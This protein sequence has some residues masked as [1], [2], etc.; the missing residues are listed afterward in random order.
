VE[1]FQ[2]AFLVGKVDKDIDIYNAQNT[3]CC[4]TAKPGQ[5]PPCCSGSL[6]TALDWLAPYCEGKK[7]FPIKTSPL[8]VW[9]PECK[10]LY[11]MAAIAF[12][13]ASYEAIYQAL[14]PDKGDGEICFGI[15]CGSWMDL[16][17]PW[18]PVMFKTDDGDTSL[19]KV[20]PAEPVSWN[21]TSSATVDPRFVSFTIDSWWLEMW[22]LPGKWHNSTLWHNLTYDFTSPRLAALVRALGPSVLRVGGGKSDSGYF[23]GGPHPGPRP[24]SH[25]YCWNLTV[26]SWESFQKFTKAS[27]VDLVYGLNGALRHTDNAGEPTSWDSRNAAAF[28]AYNRQHGH[29]VWGYEIGNEPGDHPAGP[30]GWANISLAVHAADFGALQKILA[31]EF[32]DDA[33]RPLVLGPDACMP[34]YLKG[35]LAFNPAINITTV[36]KY[37]CMDVSGSFQNCSVGDV[38]SPRLA[39]AIARSAKD[40][41]EI[42]SAAPLSL[43]L[44]EGAV[45]WN[46]HSPINSANFA[47]VP[48]YLQELGE[49]AKSG[50][51]LFA[52]QSLVDLIIPTTLEVTPN[53]WAAL[54]WKRLMG[55]QV[56]A[57]STGQHTL[58][59]MYVHNGAEDGVGV[60]SW[61]MCLINLAK[62]STAVA[63]LPGHG[64]G[65][66]AVYALTSPAA[67]ATSPAVLLNGATLRLSE[68]GS[69]PKIQPLVEACVSGLKLPPLSATFVT[70]SR[71]AV[72]TDDSAPPH[73]RKLVLNDQDWH[74]AGPPWSCSTTPSRSECTPEWLTPCDGVAE[75]GNVIFYTAE[76]FQS[77]EISF[78]FTNQHY[79]GSWS[80]GGVVFCAVNS[81]H[82][83]E[84]SVP[85]VAMQER[86]EASWVTIGSVRGD[87][88]RRAAQLIPAPG[89]G[90]APGLMHHA[91]V[92][93]SA[94]RLLTSWLDDQPL[95]AQQMPPQTQPGYV[96]LSTYSMLGGGPRVKF[97]NVTLIGDNDTDGSAFDKSVN[98]ARP[99]KVVGALNRS[100]PAKSP[101]DDPHEVGNAIVAPNGDVLALNNRS[102]LRSTNHGRTFRL[103]RGKAPPA[104]PRSYG[105]HMS[106]HGQL[107]LHFSSNSSTGEVFKCVSSDSG[108][109]FSQPRHVNTVMFG[110][111]FCAGYPRGTLTSVD[112]DDWTTESC[113]QLLG[114]ATTGYMTQ[115]TSIVRTQN[116]TIMLLGPA[117]SRQGGT[118]VKNRTY[119]YG[120]GPGISPRAAPILK[121]NYAIRSTDDGESFSDPIDLDG[122]GSAGGTMSGK[123]YTMPMG[124]KEADE[125]SASEVSPGQLLVLVRPYSSS[126]MWQS[127]S[128]LTADEGSVWGPLT[129]GGFPL[130]ACFNAMVT[131]R[132]G[133]TIVCGR[134]PGLSCQASWDAGRS[135]HLFTV[136]LSSGE[137]Q[138][139]LVEV[140]PD[141]VLW[142]Y[143]S[144]SSSTGAGPWELRSQRI[145]VLHSPPTLRPEQE[146]TNRQAL[147]ETSEGRD[148]LQRLAEAIAA[149]VAEQREL[150]LKVAAA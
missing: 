62:N 2:M 22:T 118:T 133:V 93:L 23:G 141:V 56:Y 120:E 149:D 58:T 12:Q 126:T 97:F 138:G 20:A 8:S 124:A 59:R 39:S 6:R 100:D 67:N 111:Q 130:Y 89:V 108:H 88:W 7:T 57:A 109:S 9:A 61:A 47:I 103:E 63:G 101:I 70:M 127:R 113:T 14:G 60:T 3:S 98:L 74:I 1:L 91:R 129:R 66:R 86:A 18:K 10:V 114:G 4:A 65:S 87:G 139:S 27:D 52:K 136:D 37:F 94:S 134:Y 34:D 142:I 140:E 107:V 17:W 137:A 26:P 150:V 147:A 79:L 72:K 96:G 50:V 125:I 53:Y 36:H 75:D 146:R 15:T 148:E 85:N 24:C 33:T 16:M 128:V 5:N 92:H 51:S 71:R 80:G 119:S 19:A 84:W 135:W 78:S 48:S 76:A 81:T 110:P 54:L 144:R 112:G 73:S 83:D 28:I 104:D 46:H 132:S 106:T 90:S 11:R 35:L 115:F 21:T 116:G 143:G 25:T 38:L 30:G 82:F 68:G 121:Y 131:T 32:H 31:S 41:V 49:L 105:G 55:N 29:A 69:L 13:N 99:W 145:R 122:A 64:C 45:F 102:I 123:P 95:P 117:S 43:W 40:W 42:A 44:G 77:F